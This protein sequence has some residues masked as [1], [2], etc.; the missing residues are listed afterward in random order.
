[1]VSAAPTPEE[2]VSDS[3]RV[4]LGRLLA[5]HSV[6][7][8]TF[9]LSSGKE[10]DFYVD[11]KKTMGLAQGLTLMGDVMLEAI[12]ESG[13][14]VDAVGGQVMGAVPIAVAI[15]QASYGT[16]LELNAFS[17]RKQAKIHGTRNMVE[18]PVESGDRVVILDD[19]VTSGK[20]ACAAIENC[21]A[22]GL[23]VALVLVLVDRQEDEDGMSCI[24]SAV[25]GVEV[26]ALFTR[27]DLEAWRT[28]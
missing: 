4:Q 23:E 12:R 13:I 24:R 8:G 9:T 18:G 5:E 7:F 11:C 20:S 1:M 28:L 3:K 15:S 10:S 19:V 26:K 25:P 2:N 21:Q 22:E 17:V 6:R 14:Q 16:D 27:A